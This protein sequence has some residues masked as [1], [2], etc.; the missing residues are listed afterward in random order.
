MACARLYD[1]IIMFDCCIFFESESLWLLA[2]ARMSGVLDIGEHWALVQR[3]CMY[4]MWKYLR[5]KQQFLCER[6]LCREIVLLYKLSSN[7]IPQFNFDWFNLQH[8]QTFPKTSIASITLSNVYLS[9]ILPA[10][11]GE[12]SNWLRVASGIAST[13]FLISLG[14]LPKCYVTFNTI[15]INDSWL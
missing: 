12:V 13:A 1:L 9:V 10:R 15:L 6:H 5:R 3:P 11:E 8:F 2:L 4:A 7:C 14:L